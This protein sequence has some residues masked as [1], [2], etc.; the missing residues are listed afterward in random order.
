V[1]HGEGEA[2]GVAAAEGRRRLQVDGWHDGSLHKNGTEAG[3]GREALRFLQR[4]P[5][6]LMAHAGSKGGEGKGGGGGAH[7][8]LAGV[9]L[10]AVAGWCRRVRAVQGE[11]RRRRRR[12]GRRPGEAPGRR[13]S[14]PYA[15]PAPPPP[16]CAAPLLLL[17]L[18]CGGGRREAGASRVW[19]EAASGLYGALGFGSGCGRGSSTAGPERVATS[20]RLRRGGRVCGT[21]DRGVGE[22]GSAR[23]RLRRCRGAERRAGWLLTRGCGAAA[24]KKGGKRGAGGWRRLSRSGAERSGGGARAGEP[25]LRAVGRKGKADG[26]GPPVSCPG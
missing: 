3:R 23:G 21:G 14:P 20:R 13:P 17:L 12:S 24:G 19:G 25:G 1:R 5:R 4:V 9:T 26:W 10:G 18:T 8:G 2:S 6:Q 7:R 15:A 11:R 16:P 22:K